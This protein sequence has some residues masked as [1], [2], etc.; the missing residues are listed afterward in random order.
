MSN[1]HPNRIIG[2]LGFAAANFLKS[3][4]IVY[5]LRKAENSAL[6]RRGQRGLMPPLKYW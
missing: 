5:N 4:K 6:V 2:T 1:V 3:S